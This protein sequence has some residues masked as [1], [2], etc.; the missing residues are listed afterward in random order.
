MDKKTDIYFISKILEEIDF[1]SENLC[2]LSY[3]Q[4]KNNVFLSDS[5][6]FNLYKFVNFPNDCRLNLCKFTVRYPG[7]NSLV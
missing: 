1:I 7:T 2:N 5:V 6:C 4:F 3:E